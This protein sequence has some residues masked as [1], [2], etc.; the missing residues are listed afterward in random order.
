MAKLCRHRVEHGRPPEAS[1]LDGARTQQGSAVAKCWE[2]PKLGEV[3][4][5][6]HV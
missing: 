2:R 6:Q 1:Q 3:A 4:V 5:H